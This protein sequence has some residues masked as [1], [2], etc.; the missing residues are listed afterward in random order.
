MSLILDAL[1]K[2]EHQRQRQAGPGLA[3]VPEHTVTRRPS[4]WLLLL[5][6]LLLL[7]II[8]LGA[9]L[10]TGRQPPAAAV[11]APP[12]MV[13]PATVSP[14][15]PAAT[16]PA[17][18]P[19]A[20]APPRADSAPART[21]PAPVTLPTRARR[22]DVRPLTTEVAPA[23][24]PARAAETN[25]G[26]PATPP[27]TTTP[28]SAETTTGEL[29]A[30]PSPGATQQATA[31]ARLP[32]FTDLVV[33]GELN[34]PHMRVDIHVFSAVPADRFVFINMRKYIEG[35]ATQEGPQVER[36]T[37]DGVVMDYQGQR[38]FLSRD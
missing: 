22:D 33:R 4:T 26:R 32:R 9:L 24:A 5:G 28:R 16:P 27:A 13:S 8:V 34:V 10:L 3:V 20:A 31:D 15:P 25:T 36:I 23:S 1:R 6:G 14:A 2:S 19:P 21:S 35:Q 37:R 11:T 38:F 12:A 7:N 29:P 30:G 17:D 18:T